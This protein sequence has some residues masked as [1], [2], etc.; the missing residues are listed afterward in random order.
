[1][2]V[3]TANSLSHCLGL[4]FPDQA[5]ERRRRSHALGIL[6]H[7]RLSE[8]WDMGLVWGSYTKASITRVEDSGFFW[9]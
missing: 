1:M 3:A 5:Y 9:A 8:T 6:D 2:S 7:L 4:Q